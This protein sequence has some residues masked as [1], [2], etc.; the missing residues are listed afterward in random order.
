MASIETADTLRANRRFVKTAMQARY[1]E[2]SEEH[3]LAV[4]WRADGDED[5]LHELTTAYMRLVISMASKFRNYGLSHTD[6]IQEGSVGLMQAAARFDPDRGVRFSTYAAWWIRAAIQDHVLRNWSIVRTGTTSSQKSLFFNLRRL[7]ALI[8]DVGG[9]QLSSENRA[10]VARQLK[11]SEDDVAVMASRLSGPDRSLNAPLTEDGEGATFQDFL[12]DGRPSPE[13]EVMLSRDAATRSQWLT[14][15]LDRLTPRELQ[16]I[17]ERRL[18]EDGKTLAALGH[19]LGISKERVRQI[20]RQALGK[21]RQ[22]LT[23]DLGDPRE[24]GIV[25]AEI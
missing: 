4:R 8:H 23:D 16:I 18:A 12:V 9:A 17:Q 5:A 15:A 22:A 19:D 20:E 1:L 3:E 7:R 10:Y 24:A 25:P 2:E 21:L 6:L 11:V 13:T 14:A